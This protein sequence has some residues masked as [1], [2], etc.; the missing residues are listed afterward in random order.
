MGLGSD[1]DFDDGYRAPPS[2][3]AVIAAVLFGLF[4]TAVLVFVLWLIAT[5]PI[6]V[7]VHEREGQTYHCSYYRDGD[8]SCV[9]K[10]DPDIG[11]G[12][13]AP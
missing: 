3:G 2:P 8:I 5:T 6:R 12:R 13:L 1:V 9:N 4:A 11:G 7:E 10:S